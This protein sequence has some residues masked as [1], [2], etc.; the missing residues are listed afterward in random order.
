MAEWFEEGIEPDHLAEITAKG[1][2]KPLSPE[3]ARTI[4]TA[5]R[6]ATSMLGVPADQLMR[7]PK[8]AADPLYQ[9]AYDRVVG[10]SIPKTPEEYTFDDVKFKDGSA[11]DAADAQ[12]VRDWAVANKVSLPAARA[13]AAAMVARTDASLEVANGQSA[14]AKQANEN[15]LALA[16]GQNVE[17]NKASA[18]KA[19][20]AL[21]VLG[22]NVSFDGLDPAGYAA[23]M[24]GLVKL[25]TQLDEHVILRSSG[26]G[27]GPV[28]A[29]AGM[30]PADATAK[31]NE[32]KE[33]QDWVNKALTPGTQEATYF[34]N[35]QRVMAG[36][37]NA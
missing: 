28:P 2:N 35:L 26:G 37:P 22:I 30:T 4:A 20:D 3:I 14:V 24:G 8:D 36:V 1:W 16:W 11:L 32:L 5:H 25:S 31:F 29:T 17:V 34:A 15:A 10:L 33:N 6:A 19:A 9:V 27:N 7:L 23:A 21:K 12:F 18:A 13:M